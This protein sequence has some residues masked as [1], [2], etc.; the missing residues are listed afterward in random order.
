MRIRIA[1]TLAAVVGTLACESRKEEAPPQPTTAAAPAT[2]PASPPPELAAKPS[3]A[4][5]QV[6]RDAAELANKIE[7]A[8]SEADKLLTSA[9][10]T[11]EQF[12][13]KLYTIAEDPLL[14]AEYSRLF[15]PAPAG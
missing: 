10:T 1:L 8:P 3:E 9:G 11:R 15:E 4:G 14:S 12:I 5:L 2:P 6:A 13:E 7:R